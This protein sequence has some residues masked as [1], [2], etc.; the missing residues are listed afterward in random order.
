MIKHSSPR[1]QFPPDS[2]VLGS[3]IPEIVSAFPLPLR[4]HSL[5]IGGYFYSVVMLNFLHASFILFKRE[6]SLHFH[7]TSS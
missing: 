6:L 7:L 5:Y 1:F 4:C 3:L 2:S